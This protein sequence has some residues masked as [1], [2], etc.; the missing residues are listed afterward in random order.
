MNNNLSGNGSQGG[1]IYVEVSTD[2][3]L[4]ENN[5]IANNTASLGSAILISGSTVNLN[6]NTIAD[7]T[8]TNTFSNNRAAIF[9]QSSLMD[10]SNTIFWN[11][12]QAIFHA[13]DPL[14]HF[15]DTGKRMLDDHAVAIGPVTLGLFS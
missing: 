10:I 6:F 3:I 4:I 11:V 2:P 8:S 13:D 9:P 7:N 1:G 5:L 14:G 15:K 12:D